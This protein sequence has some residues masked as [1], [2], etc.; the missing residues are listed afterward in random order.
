[1]NDRNLA[2]LV[3]SGLL[4]IAAGCSK[5]ADTVETKSKAT[6]ETAAGTVH[7]SS[8]STRVG[9]T[10]EAST[11]TEVDTPSGTTKM[12]TETVVGTVTEYTPGKKVEVMAGDKNAHAFALDDKDVIYSVD[13]ALAVGKRVTVIDETGDDK[14]RHVTVRLER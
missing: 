1:M 13:S 4:A 5:P 9:T 3:S 8:E 11:K 14:I 7:T 10:L 2:I 6:T 12:E